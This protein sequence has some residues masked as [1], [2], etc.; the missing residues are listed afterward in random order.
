MVFDFYNKDELFKL[1]SGKNPSKI[2]KYIKVLESLDKK[3]HL[4][5]KCRKHLFGQIDQYFT[6]LKE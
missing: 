2:P 6:F 5:K 3:V 1:F 4:D